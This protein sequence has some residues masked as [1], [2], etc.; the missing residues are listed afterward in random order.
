MTRPIVS[1]AQILERLRA[2]AEQIRACGVRRL[3]LFGSF[4]R[5]EGGPG[6]DIDFVVDF[7]PDEKTYDNFL[8]LSKLLEELLGHPVELVTRESLSPY[9]GPSILNEAEDVALRA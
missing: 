6:S 8:A 4:V 9:L 7:N 2:S 1:K 3:E 5:D